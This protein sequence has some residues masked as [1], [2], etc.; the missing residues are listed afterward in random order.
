MLSA[1][2]RRSGSLVVN[3]HDARA[4]QVSRDTWIIFASAAR[5]HQMAEDRQASYGRVEKPS[6]KEM[7]KTLS[8]RWTQQER[9]GERYR[10]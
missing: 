10:D 1:V 3:R 8:W 9:P 5:G 6:S 4:Y 2:A 7:I